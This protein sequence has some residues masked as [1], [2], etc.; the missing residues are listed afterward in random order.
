MDSKEPPLPGFTP[1]E[2]IASTSASGRDN[3]EEI[4]PPAAIALEMRPGDAGLRQ[5]RSRAPSYA[6]SEYIEIVRRMRIRSHATALKLPRNALVPVAL[7]PS[8]QG[9]SPDT[10]PPT[11]PYAASPASSD[12][13]PP[14][15]ITNSWEFAGWGA[16]SYFELSHEEVAEA[17]KEEEERKTRDGEGVLGAWL[18]SGVAG[19]AVA[20]SPL[21]AFPALVGVASVYSPI[22]LLVATMLLTCWQPI[23]KELAAALPISGANYAYLLNS[24]GSLLFALLSASLTIL[25]DVATSV[26]A[27]ATASS[28]VVDESHSSLGTAP[29]TI[30]LLFGITAIGLVGVKGSA[31]VTLAT[32][33]FHLLT[34]AI[35]LIAAAVHWGQ[36]GN[37]QLQS[38]WSAGQLGS[39]S[40]IA[41]AIFQGICMAFLGVTGYETAPD[42][43]AA[44]RP[45]PH[46]YPAVLRSLQI[47]ALLINAPLLLCTFA[48]LPS[49]T[50]LSTTSVLSTLGNVSAGK[51]LG[52]LVTVDA[53]LI[54]CATILAGLVAAIA[55]LHRL[56][57]DGSLPRVLL[58]PLPYSGVPWIATGLFAALCILVYASSGAN[59]SVVS[60]MF[61]IVFLSVMLL[62]PLSL[63][64]L[65]YNRPSLPRPLSPRT[66]F[67]LP[68]FTLFL[69]LALI[70]GVISVD[71]RS[72]GYFAA[73]LAGIAL[74]VCGC[75]RRGTVLRVVWWVA[76]RKMGWSGVAKWSVRMMERSKKGKEI[77]L[78]VKSDEINT[79]FQRILYVQRNEETSCVKLV[80]FYGPVGA[81]G[82]GVKAN[83]G[84]TEDAVGQGGRPEGIEKIPS[85][86]EA[87]FRIL[88]E[89]F[90][91]I[92]VDLVFL[93]A[94]FSPPYIHAVA[95]RLKLPVA[96]C[97]MGSPSERWPREHSWGLRDVAGVRVIDG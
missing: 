95:R 61:A 51:W 64:L 87:N 66:S 39:A 12:K 41:K 15:N 8:G 38:N 70:G 46:I 13:G 35:L 45:Q 49:D 48:V 17:T 27:A 86:L 52:T 20:G 56:S 40:K 33:S 4:P 69:A 91:S 9:D 47:I 82:G 68:L 71:P 81:G 19:V 80:H 22:A 24:S 83:A 67:L 85:E 43:I 96:R 29:L 59:L 23:M 92:T 50:I 26:V 11:F 21:Y 54:L 72:V 65:T 73:Y 75:A 77:V 90:P 34:F 79:L 5:R 32:L 97:F 31:S 62:Y 14:P 53:V 78:F 7:R 28:Y 25:D 84:S 74:L 44:L 3:I 63:L 88:D 55:L 18:A 42:Y 89:A 94:P 58:K 6:E 10:Y 2:P 57:F 76:E 30:I 36:T 60:S 1:L 37:A 93:Q 16:M